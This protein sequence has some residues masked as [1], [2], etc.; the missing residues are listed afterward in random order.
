MSTFQVDSIEIQ[1]A[2]KAVKFTLETM[3]DLVSQFNALS[4]I[5]PATGDPNCANAFTGFIDMWTYESAEITK[6]VAAF[7]NNLILAANEY[8]YTEAALADQEI[9]TFDLESL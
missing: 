7:L 6:A 5:A 9:Y 1:R 3:V 4:A 2:A 8:A